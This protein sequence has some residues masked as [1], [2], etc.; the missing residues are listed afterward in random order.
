V[1]GT[2]RS[3]GVIETVRRAARNG[4]DRTLDCLTGGR[5]QRGLVGSTLP[6]PQRRV[7]LVASLEEGCALS[8]SIEDYIECPAASPYG[9]DLTH[10][11]KVN[12]R[13]LLRSFYFQGSRLRELPAPA[14]ERL[15]QMGLRE[16]LVLTLIQAQL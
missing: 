4:D 1:E 7:K 6:L 12:G 9:H 16:W 10:F 3:A 15:R 8:F 11:E 2:E 13:W 14:P 5:F